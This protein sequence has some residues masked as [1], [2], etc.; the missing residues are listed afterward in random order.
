VVVAG[1]HT[2]C[3][4]QLHGS[5]VRPVRDC[6]SMVRPA[7]GSTRRRQTGGDG[8]ARLVS[9]MQPNQAPRVQLAHDWLAVL[10]TGPV[11]GHAKRTPEAGS[12]DTRNFLV[13]IGPGCRGA[14]HLGVSYQTASLRDLAR[15]KR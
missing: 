13:S 12:V 8:R 11:P 2:T 14:A 15:Q 7:H 10:T 6:A 3:C 1:A 9:W 5:T 4:A